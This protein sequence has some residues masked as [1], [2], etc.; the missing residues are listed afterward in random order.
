MPTEAYDPYAMHDDDVQAPPRS[1]WAALKRMCVF[2]PSLALILYLVFRDPRSMV[3]FGG[4][5]Q[6]ATL[7]VISAA[8]L[9]LRY[10]RTD[11]RIAPSAIS[12]AFL[13]IA[14][15]TISLVAA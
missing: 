12:D 11:A 15:L 4:F 3:V 2:H 5:F 8:A 1:L 13:W 9:Y 6:A 14:L 7:P 10:R